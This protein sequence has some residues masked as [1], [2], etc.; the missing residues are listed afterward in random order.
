MAVL[1]DHLADTERCVL[2]HETERSADPLGD[3]SLGGGRVE[4]NPAAGELRRIEPAKHH[5][6]VGDGWL[7]A[8]LT[9]TSRARL[10]PGAVRTHCYSLQQVDAGDRAATST[11][12]DHL[13][14]RNSQRQPAAFEKTIDPRHLHGARHLRPCLVDEAYLR[15]GPAH[16]E[17]KDLRQPMLTRDA[18]G[19]NRARCGPGLD[20]AH[21]EANG[22][23]DGRDPAAGGH[24]QQRTCKAG[25][26]ELRSRPA[27]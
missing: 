3:G 14:H 26:L 22:S 27:R 5:I 10:R 25:A 1:V 16:V 20:Q 24:Q 13:D 17:R 15:G 12:L 4:R 9:V 6:G 21:R 2:F 11:D 7:A 23:I 8:A 19:K 18:A